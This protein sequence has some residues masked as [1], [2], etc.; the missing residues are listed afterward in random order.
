MSFQDSQP[1]AACEPN[2]SALYKSVPNHSVSQNIIQRLGLSVEIT[3][4]CIFPSG[5]S[6]DLS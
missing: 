5:I 2:G 6:K 1:S 3:M 4:G